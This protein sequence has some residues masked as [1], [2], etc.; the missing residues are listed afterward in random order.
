MPL[1]DPRARRI[2]RLGDILLSAGILVLTLPLL[3]LCAA[4]IALTS[5]GPVLFA[6]ERVGLDGAVF[7]MYKLRT[8]SPDAP[9]R[10]DWTRAGDPRR[11][12]LGAVLRRYSLDELPQLYNVL[13]GDMSLVGPR[14]EMPCHVE[15]FRREIPDYALR[16]RVRPGLTGWAQVHGLRGDTSIPR[17][18]EHDLWYIRHWSIGLDLYILALTPLRCLVN[19]QEPLLPRR[20]RGEGKHVLLVA[21]E[22]IPS[23]VLCAKAPLRALC[24]TGKLDGRCVTPSACTPGD[25]AWADAVVFVRADDA[26]SLAAAKLARRAG[27]TCVYVLDD[28]LFAVPPGLTSAA[29]YARRDTRSRL[30]AIM[31][32]CQWLLSPSSALLEKYGGGFAHAAR[33]EEPALPAERRDA[34]VGGAVRVGFAGSE[35]RTGDVETI[36]LGALRRLKERYGEEISID[37]FGARPAAVAELGARRL[38][39]ETDY[40]LYRRTMGELRW[41]VGLAPL[42]DTPFHRCKHYNKFIEYASFGIAG[43]YSDVDVYRAAVRH[44]ENGL[45]AENTEDAWFA[46]LCRLVEDVPLRRAIAARSL[47]E[48]HTRYSLETV[49]QTWE[50]ILASM[51]TAPAAPWLWCA[52]GAMAAR[53]L[54]AR[55]RRLAGHFLRR[56]R[57]ALRR[58]EGRA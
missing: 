34:R 46:A 53:R 56:L 49:A 15:R 40:A 12:R 20:E 22:A 26:L 58:R 23:V 32:E 54:Y 1:D 9:A 11:T 45:L 41:D 51:P 39:Y 48:A 6:Q 38:P 30:R 2:K 17:R 42:P 8:M 43:V 18:V 16:H 5:P 57:Q 33:I 31:G 47:S 10:G 3:G 29:Y 37:F 44:G 13:R 28:D 14:P 4:F 19:R 55:A 7:T 36:A 25:L 21:A 50:T 27:R 52:F 24:E 35:D